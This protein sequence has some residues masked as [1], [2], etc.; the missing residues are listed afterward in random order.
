VRAQSRQT[1][2]GTREHADE[3]ANSGQLFLLQEE[4]VPVK[5]IVFVQP[6][7]RLSFSPCNAQPMCR[8]LEGKDRPASQPSS[9]GKTYTPSRW[10]ATGHHI[11]PGWV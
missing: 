9:S 11:P 5:Q 3:Q 2:G 4:G 1:K 10:V 6:M 7:Y 8:K